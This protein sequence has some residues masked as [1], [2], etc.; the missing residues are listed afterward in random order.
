MKNAPF[1]RRSIATLVGLMCWP[2]VNA[3]TPQ[4]EAT[5]PIVVAQATDAKAVPPKNDS[6]A[7]TKAE[8]P[9]KDVETIVVQGAYFSPA[10]ESAMKLDIAVR[11]TPL[12]V[13]NYSAEFMKAIESS[14]TLDL[15]KYM[16]GVN[17]GG[18]SA[19]DLS[20]RGFKTTSNDRNALMTDGLPGQVS[21]FASPPTIGI[22]HIEVVKGPASVLYGQAQPGGFVNIILK[23]PKDEAAAIVDLKANGYKGD[24]VSWGKAHG[25]S[26][27]VDFTGPIDQDRKFSYRLVAENSDRTG[28]RNNTFDLSQ[29]VAPSLTWDMSLNTS[30]TVIAEYRFRRGAQDLYLPAP[31]RELSRLPSRTTRLQEPD[32]FIKEEGRSTSLFFSHAITPKV[33]WRL[34]ARSVRNHDYTKWYDTV[35]VLPNLTTLQRRARIGDNRRKSDY[36]ETSISADLMTGPIKHKILFGVTGGKDD[37]DANRVQFV[38]GATT[39][40]LAVPGPGSLNINIYNPVYGLAPL[41]SSLAAGTFQRRVTASEPRGAFITDFVEF[42]E[43]W[44]ASFGIRYAKEK[45]SFRELTSSVAILPPRSETPSDS[46]PMAGLLFQPNQQWTIYSSYSTSFV[47]IAPNMQN[48]SGVFDFKPEKGKQIEGGVKADLM[49]GKLYF[50][51]AFFDIE[52]VN[53]LALVT[54]NTGIAGTCMQPVG[55]E[56]SRGAEFE[57]NVRPVKNWQIAFGVAQVDAKIARSNTAA[58]APLVGS[59]LTNAPRRKANLWS[60][61]DFVTGALS[62]FG[63]GVGLVHV[64]EQAGNLPTTANA[65]VL[66]LPA[67]TVADAGIYYRYAGKYDLALKVS[68]LSD[69]LYYDS[70]GSTLADLSVVPGAP[71]NFTFTVRIPL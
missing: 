27:G 42:S 7:P 49:K 64:S 45:Q 30:V 25:Y 16:T 61:Y 60:R 32:D 6:K 69:K 4:A 35:S 37:L 21:R 20:L 50:T 2:A 56:T 63:F 59:Q 53:T 26:A 66:K 67:Y 15:Y 36:L 58:T 71:R 12:S 22:D 1:A 14:E 39:G 47:P 29:Y 65:R 48:A 3:Q 51:L 52:K 9:A 13:T 43:K 44:K 68:N 54:C 34:S 11:D 8:P 23:K 19:Y 24:G 62:G 55:M 5:Q 46:Y 17:R 41:H 70:V 18:Q 40:A 10:A 31:S 38:N 57:A 33:T 28:W